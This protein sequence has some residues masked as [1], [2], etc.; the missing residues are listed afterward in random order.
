M[1]TDFL[2]HI[3]NN[4]IID[5]SKEA[6]NGEFSAKILDLFSQEIG[7]PAPALNLLLKCIV[8]LPPSIDT[9]AL[10][11]TFLAKTTGSTTSQALGLMILG[12]A[13]SGN[14][15][16]MKLAF[17]QL[18]SMGINCKDLRDPLQENQTALHLACA[19]GHVEMA[20]F[21]IGK[22]FSVNARDQDG[23][24]PLH[25]AAGGTHAGLV[26]LLVAKGGNVHERNDKGR[27]P[28]FMA[29]NP[30][31]FAI[32][33]QNGVNVRVYDKDGRSPLHQA[34]R[35]QNQTIINLLLQNQASLIDF[36]GFMFLPCHYRQPE[37]RNPIHLELIKLAVEVRDRNESAFTN[38]LNSW[39][40]L[41]DD[42]FNNLISTAFASPALVKAL[43]AC[44]FEKERNYRIYNLPGDKSHL[45][46]F[47]L[48]EQQT[49]FLRDL[50]Q[51]EKDRVLNSKIHTGP[52][53]YKTPVEILNRL[54][55]S[56]NLL[57]LNDQTV[58]IF[59]NIPPLAIAL[60][61]QE[62]QYRAIL[63]R[64]VHVM[65][66]E[67]MAVF[68]PQLP[69][70]EWLEQYRKLDLELR[71][72]VNTYSAPEQLQ[73]LT[74][75]DITIG[76]LE[77]VETKLQEIGL[78]NPENLENIN[79]QIM[80]CSSRF[81]ALRLSFSTFALS[82]ENPYLDKQ[83]AALAPLIQSIEIKIND[84]AHRM[85]LLKDTQDTF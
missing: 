3:K 60:L 30:E 41:N 74:E 59:R 77:D 10:T 7:K 63:N 69:P 27:T 13:A 82:F 79:D 56:S 38:R 21:L 73:L 85:N 47:C 67:Q 8:I 81:V 1:H 34:F 48:P 72:F 17:A 44:G 68:F 75:K 84:L 53:Q 66:K 29:A 39:A 25:I 35:S 40:C 42:D 15:N 2:S 64:L 18:E 32:L 58:A 11:A 23:N 16:T 62:S 28:V 78:I 33:M 54:D 6:A 55:Q 70:Q 22:G 51:I 76:E 83:R 46:S 61:A 36:D 9:T 20:E 65:D 50:P 14:L 31:V 45:L 12:T 71:D 52:K 57:F 49:Q 43:R 5:L 26:Q 4:D 24:T 19:N 37:I 80:A